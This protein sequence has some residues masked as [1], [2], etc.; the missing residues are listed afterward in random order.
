L[1]IWIRRIED[2]V[3][4]LLLVSLIVIAGGQILLRNVFST[5]LSWTDE[6]LRI[7]VL[8]LAMAGAVAASRGDRHISI[9]LLSRLLPP[10]WI[11][12]MIALTSLFTAG[13][14]LILSYQSWVFVS[15]SREFEDLLLGGLPAWPFQI[16]LPIAFAL[17]TVRY[18]IFAAQQFLPERPGHTP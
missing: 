6:M 15:A 2:G 12:Y 8:W 9:D 4:A 18:L 16:I 10:S 11:R 13:V 3:L 5:G 1:L 14:C 17:I 7:L